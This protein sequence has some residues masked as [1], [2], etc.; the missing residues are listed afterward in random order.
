MQQR[1]LVAECELQ[2]SVNERDLISIIPSPGPQTVHNPTLSPP[3]I[4]S[5][6]RIQNSAARLL[7]TRDHITP[8]LQNLH[9]LLVPQRTQFKS[10]HNQT[11]LPASL[12]RSIATIHRA[13]SVHL[14]QTS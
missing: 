1:H 7:Y 5:D 8:V 6:R 3:P 4:I 11:P 10:L 9:W 12:T 14:M 2:V 13:A